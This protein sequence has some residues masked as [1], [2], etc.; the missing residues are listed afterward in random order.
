LEVPVLMLGKE[1]RVMRN[2]SRFVGR[3][4]VALALLPALWQPE[5]FGTARQQP[6]ERISKPGQ[7]RGYSKALFDGWR[8]TSQYVVVR[9][10]T[11]IAIDIF[12]PTREG[13]LHQAPLPVIWEQRRYQRASIDP[14]GAIHSQLDRQD[15]PM[16][17]LVL[18]G[19]IFAVADV[20]GAGASFGARVDPTPP[21]E[22][23]DAYDITEWLA[24]QS[25]CTG[26]VGM[27]GIS[28]GGSAQFMAARA[29]PPHLKAAFPEMAMFDL[30]DFA[31]PGG[32]F[33]Y[34]FLKAWRQQT[35]TLDSSQARRAAPVDE[36]KDQHL[37]EQA[38]RQHQHNFDVS[39]VAQ[40][41]YR[42]G[43]AGNIGRICA[44][45]SPSMY[46]DA[47]N[48]SGVAI[49]LRAGWFD[50]YPRDMLL[51]FCN[52]RTPKK[53]AIGPWDHYQS[54][55]LDR[56]TEMLRWFDY[57]LKDIDNGIMKEPPILYCVMGA[58]EDKTIRWAKQWPLPEA[59]PAKYYFAA[60]SSGSVKSVNDG[61]LS[62]SVAKPG[63]DSYVVDYST[64]SGTRSRW[65]GGPPAY[66]DMA[67]N[68]RK[69]LTY[70]TEPLTHLVEIVGH[71][72]L[73]LWLQCPTGDVDV[74]AYLEEVDAQGRS[75][76]ITEGCL[77]ASH[78]ALT[79]PPH[80]RLGLPYH[81][82]LRKDT[83]KLPNEPVELVFDLL[84]T[85]RHFPAGHRIRIAVACADKDS[86][87]TPPSSPA[88]TITVFRDAE[89]PSYVILP[90]V[91]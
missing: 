18:H 22:S 91:N 38:I 72:I 86:Y 57:W 77:R 36:D 54:Q 32:I 30:Y 35:Q 67:A 4:L 42:D 7:Y 66:P 10:R 27:Y 63:R 11:R 70:T 76:Y 60:G 13:S 26:N 65:T 15:H 43:T 39:R 82:G 80:A 83:A 52:L 69:A 90:V 17:K 45:N 85:G 58:P 28:Y 8:R 87:Q 64:T 71:P 61:L 81:S 74:F 37:L 59:K 1:Y 40:I 6:E 41:P 29:C 3:T 19:Y 56:G 48:K 50:M 46:V 14:S 47:V 21:Q 79:K 53:I 84:P 51:W 78:R 89:H 62:P 25:W 16:R 12:R 23:L 75:T 31:Y 33:R 34:A 68:D 9:D 88:P 2:N 5:G 55:G 73:H 24:A 49:Y 44:D 20:R